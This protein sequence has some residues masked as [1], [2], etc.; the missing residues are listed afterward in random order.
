VDLAVAA[1]GSDAPAVRTPP[2]T[3]TVF[4]DVTGRTA[5]VWTLEFAALVARV[6]N[7]ST[8]AAKSDCPLI[9]LARFGEQRTAAGSLRHDGNVL[10]VSGVEGDHDAGTLALADAAGRCA[11]A[12][13]AAV[14]YT[15]P[16]HT[17][18]RPRWRVLAP[19]SRPHYQRSAAASPPG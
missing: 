8:Y 18:E 13:I 5:R 2:F 12:G 19:L 17:P 6:A 11:Q 3:V 7:L 15:T 10:E 14:F 9:K 16:S 4:P 1:P